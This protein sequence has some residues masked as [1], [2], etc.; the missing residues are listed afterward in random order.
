MGMCTYERKHIE[1]QL[2]KRY[3]NLDADGSD[4]DSEK[5]WEVY[6]SLPRDV[7][8]WVLVEQLNADTYFTT[9]VWRRK[10]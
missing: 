8:D 3:P 5:C 7:V 10:S 1:E 6:N 2:R 9:W 4:E